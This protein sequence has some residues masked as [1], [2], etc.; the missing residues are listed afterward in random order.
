[1]VMIKIELL[2]ANR[3]AVYILDTHIVLVSFQLL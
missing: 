3:S 1:M 2:L